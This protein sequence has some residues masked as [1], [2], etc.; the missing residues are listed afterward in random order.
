MRVAPGVAGKMKAAG[1]RRGWPDLQ[2][3]CLD[4]VTRYIELKVVR[5]DSALSPEQQAFRA[6]AEPL[7][8]WAKATSVAEV[9]AG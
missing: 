3:A 9:E 8:I 5:A 1:V 4:G 6:W 2:L 7:G